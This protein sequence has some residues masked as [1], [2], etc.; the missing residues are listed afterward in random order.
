MNQKLLDFL[1]NK[2]NFNTKNEIDEEITNLLYSFQRELDA[3]LDSGSHTAKFLRSK[4]TG[5]VSKGNNHYGYPYQVLDYSALLSRE[6]SFSFRTSVWYGNHFSFAL[7]LSGHFLKEIKVEYNKLAREDYLFTIDENIWETDFK[8]THHQ[9][10]ESVPEAGFYEL[11][12]KTNQI[13]IFK[14]FSLNQTPSLIRLGI[15][16]FKS[17]LIQ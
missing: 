14:H 12:S 10:L 9:E 1:Q 15:E 7:I 11:L 2:E 13:K 6:A 17:L 4:Q 3:I 8:K 5:K 16:S